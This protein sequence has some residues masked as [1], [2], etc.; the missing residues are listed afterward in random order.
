MKALDDA[1]Q[2]TGA[3]N[4]V[5]AFTMSDFGRTLQPSGSGTDHGWGSHHFVVG[6]AVHGG[7]I[8]GTFPLMT[9]YKTLNATAED[10]ADNRGV[11]L[12]RLSLSQYGA[13]LAKWFGA[14]PNATFA[15]LGA[16]G[17]AADLGLL[18]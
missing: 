12:P 6:G 17:G 7:K 8:Y 2:Q 4:S 13:T 15:N 16:W 18:G 10:Y 1:T 11:L 3:G 14:D 9:N 5:T